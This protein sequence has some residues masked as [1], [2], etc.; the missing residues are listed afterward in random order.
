MIGQR[1]GRSCA[2]RVRVSKRGR[3]GW[4]LQLLVARY[5]QMGGQESAV[6]VSRDGAFGS[7]RVQSGETRRSQS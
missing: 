2:N 5:G 1:R 6:G 4:L 3:R 7:G